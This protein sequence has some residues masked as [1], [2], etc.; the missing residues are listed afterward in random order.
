MLYI[1]L[2][3]TL[4]ATSISPIHLTV[5]FSLVIYVGAFVFITTCPSED[6]SSILFVSLVIAIVAIAMK[7]AS[8]SPLTLA[9]LHSTFKVARIAC[10][11]LPSILAFTFWFSVNI[12]ATVHVTIYVYVRASSVLQT[13]VPLSFVPISIFPGVDPEAMGL[14]LVPLSYVTV[15]LEPSPDS[16]TLF[17]PSAPLS[18]VD[19]AVDPCVNA[20]T[21]SFPVLKLA[22]VAI[23]RRVTLKTFA[24]TLVFIPLALILT[25]I[26]IFDYS[27]SHT[28]PISHIADVNRTMW[29]F[30]F[31]EA[32]LGLQLS[33][34]HFIR[35]KNNLVGSGTFEGLL[36]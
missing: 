27:Q 2:P 22:K 19:L 17:E 18:I 33:K 20:L 6:S 32:R 25:P 30:S 5:T 3:I 29:K 21:I 31:G 10:T 35:F 28:L 14:T 11:I 4:V 23:T 26:P 13:H 34:R 16:V 1:A 12:I 7:T 8:T 15:V 24:M 9:F 36:I